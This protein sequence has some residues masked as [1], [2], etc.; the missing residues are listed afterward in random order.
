MEVQV[1]EEGSETGKKLKKNPLNGMPVNRL[2]F[3]QVGLSSA[4]I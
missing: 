2:P 1:T 3:W 4:G